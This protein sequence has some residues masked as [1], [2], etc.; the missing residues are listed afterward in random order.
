MMGKKEGYAM[1]SIAK[2]LIESNF[3]ALSA[4]IGNIEELQEWFTKITNK[5]INIM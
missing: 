3:L 5:E 1:E 4:T 2:I